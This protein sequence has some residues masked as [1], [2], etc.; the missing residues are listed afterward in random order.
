MLNCELDI[1]LGA[2]C[3]INWPHGPFDDNEHILMELMNLSLHLS[4]C[5][6]QCFVNVLLHGCHFT[7]CLSVNSPFL[8]IV[9]ESFE[10]TLAL[11]DLI[12][13]PTLWGYWDSRTYWSWPN[14]IL[15][16][17]SLI[18][19]NLI[20]STIGTYQQVE[21]D[22]CE[23]T[24]HLIFIVANLFPKS[25]A[26]IVQLGL[27]W[28][29]ESHWWGDAN[30]ISIDCKLSLGFCSNFFV[31]SN[32]FGSSNKVLQK[33]YVVCNNNNLPTKAISWWSCCQN[34]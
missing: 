8:L 21:L 2:N 25:L 19:L 20:C 30:G 14:I 3:N 6:H 29:L 18:M 34:G 15:T 12:L 33:N 5:S 1:I 22:K 27:L 16:T 9:V 26:K 13:F 17:F 31:H 7:P 10:P 32:P 23:T 4:H 24:W 11:F 28:S